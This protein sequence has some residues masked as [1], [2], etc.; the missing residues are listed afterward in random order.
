MGERGE[1]SSRARTRRSAKG[2]VPVPVPVPVSVPVSV[3]P[4]SLARPRPRLRPVLS[5]DDPTLKFLTPLCLARKCGAR[6]GP[7]LTLLERALFRV[8]HS[9]AEHPHAHGPDAGRSLLGLGHTAGI[10]RGARRRCVTRTA[11]RSFDSVR[12]AHFRDRV[13]GGA[14]R[15]SDP[16]DDTKHERRMA[17]PAGP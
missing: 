9:R 1:T 6:N 11:R 10:D 4:L 16:D 14:A 17:S 2:R 12:R 15:L 5:C 7:G 13:R 3:F 8:S